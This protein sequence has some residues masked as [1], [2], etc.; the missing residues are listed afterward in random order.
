MS[1]AGLKLTFPSRTRSIRGLTT[2]VLHNRVWESSSTPGFFFA[3]KNPQ[4]KYL[5]EFFLSKNSLQALFINKITLKTLYHLN[6]FVPDKNNYKRRSENKNIFSPSIPYFPPL[7]I[8]TLKLTSPIPNTIDKIP[9]H[10]GTAQQCAGV[11]FNAGSAFLLSEKPTLNIRR[12][13]SFIMGR[14]VLFYK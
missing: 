6:S 1:I 11:L 14:V 3:L 10:N 7:S 8:A 9:H 2:M 12:D 5:K 4:P 13:D